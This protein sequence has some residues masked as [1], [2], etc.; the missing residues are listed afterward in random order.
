VRESISLTGQ[1]EAVDEILTGR[2]NLIM[3]AD[4]RRVKNAGTVADDLLERFGL[5]DAAGRRVST[6]GTCGFVYRGWCLDRPQHPD[7]EGS[8]QVAGGILSVRGLGTSI[9]RP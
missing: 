2:E 9:S 8:D 1:F 7:T 4:L 5:A 6:S 3:I